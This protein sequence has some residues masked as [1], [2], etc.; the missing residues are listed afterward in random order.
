MLQIKK[1]VALIL[2]ADRLDMFLNP[3]KTGPNLIK[4]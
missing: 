4:V 2:S 1:I 3:I